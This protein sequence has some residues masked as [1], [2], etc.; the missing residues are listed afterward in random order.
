MADTNTL[1]TWLWLP[2]FF[3][4]AWTKAGADLMMGAR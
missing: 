2:T 3:A 1:L 4:L